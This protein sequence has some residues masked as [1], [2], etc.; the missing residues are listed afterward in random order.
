[1]AQY[2]CRNCVYK[3]TCGDNMRT[4][5]CTGRRTKSGVERSMYV[6]A[7]NGIETVFRMASEKQIYNMLL[8]GFNVTMSSREEAIKFA[9]GE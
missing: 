9:K 4:E 5:P 8:D 6:K 1:M 7:S 3:A 2:P